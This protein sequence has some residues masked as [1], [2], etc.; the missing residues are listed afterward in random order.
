MPCEERR[1]FLGAVGALSL[2]QHAEGSIEYVGDP[3]VGG[4]AGLW[5]PLGTGLGL[6]LDQGPDDLRSLVFTSEPL[7][8]P[9]EITG[10]PVATLWVTLAEGE[11]LTLV[12]K[13]CEVLPEGRS[14]LVTTG[15]LQ[16]AHRSSHERPEPIPA[17]ECC[18]YQVQLWATSYRVRAGSRLRVSVA[19][20]DFPRIWPTRTN[21]RIRLFTG[22]GRPSVIALPLAIPSGLTAPDLPQPDPVVNRA[23]ATV[24]YEPRWSIER[25][26]AVDAVSVRS[27]MRLELHTPGRDGSL[28]LDHVATA[29][30]TRARPDGATVTGKTSMECRTPSG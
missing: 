29:R 10:S 8:E 2:E 19:C 14:S 18:K 3:T 1:L 25:D 7:P 6:P 22:G 5:D 9:V 12:V 28:V 23:P 16:G 4:H 30:V 26:L 27:G 17:G 11:E 24:G 13:L 20:A 15:W 21:P